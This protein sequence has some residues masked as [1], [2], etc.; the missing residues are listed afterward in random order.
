MNSLLQIRGIITCC[1]FFFIIL[2]VAQ[3]A[4]AVDYHGQTQTVSSALIGDNPGRESLSISESMRLNLR[5]IGIRD[6][7]FHSYVSAQTRFDPDWKRDTR[8]RLNTGYFRLKNILNFGDVSLGRQY[9]TLG[10]FSSAF[11]GISLQLRQKKFSEV[12]AYYGSEVPQKDTDLQDWTH[13]RVIAAQVSI[14]AIERTRASVSYRR[15]DRDNRLHRH[16]VSLDASR[17]VPIWELHIHGSVDLDLI[18][19]QVRRFA[20][21]A[22]YLFYTGT[23]LYGEFVHRKPGTHP[24]SLMSV[25]KQSPVNEIHTGFRAKKT[26]PIQF[27]GRYTASF[28]ADRTGNQVSMGLRTPVGSFTAGQDMM[29]NERRWS[30]YYQSSFSVTKQMNVR[31]YLNWIG[32]RYQG[33]D[34]SEKDLLRIRT[35]FDYFLLKKITFRIDLENG[36][37]REPERGYFFRLR[38]S[39]TYR[40]SN[41]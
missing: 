22:K 18:Q 30:A 26:G 7:T 23:Q 4:S 11:D 29:R 2:S 20:L 28:Y 15:V 32:Y 21:E 41:N 5:N 13:S 8:Y 17:F 19:D 31:V 24:H 6:L 9:M 40:F 38:S 3:C 35:R 10:P 36:S 14:D 33:D 34:N 39:V 12:K 27:I 1:R 37:R 25:F 16:S